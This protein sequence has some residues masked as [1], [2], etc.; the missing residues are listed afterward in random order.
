MKKTNYNIYCDTCNKMKH[1]DDKWIMLSYKEF[2]SDYRE[3][4][5][6]STA[7]IMMPEYRRLDFCS[8][9]HFID[10]FE[11]LYNRVKREE[12]W[13]KCLDCGKELAKHGAIIPDAWSR[14]NVEEGYHEGSVCNECHFKRHPDMDER[15]KK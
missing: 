6:C 10:Y 4:I 12:Y 14:Y 13:I 1:E 9:F 7:M 5:G 11:K 15:V 8:F 2:S 3:Y